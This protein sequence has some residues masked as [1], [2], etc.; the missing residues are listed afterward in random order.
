MKLCLENKQALLDRVLQSLIMQKDTQTVAKTLKLLTC[1]VKLNPKFLTKDQTR[2]ISCCIYNPAQA[3]RDET[4][5]L[6]LTVSKMFEEDNKLL[7]IQQLPKKNEDGS[8]VDFEINFKSEP[9]KSKN[10]ILKLFKL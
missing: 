6:L 10:Q 2:Q 9:N 5:N 4:I 3:I 8:E 1:L 7:Q